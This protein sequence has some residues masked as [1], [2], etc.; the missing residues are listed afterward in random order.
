MRRMR[1]RRCCRVHG[2]GSS[3]LERNTFQESAEGGALQVGHGRWGTR[4]WGS[5]REVFESSAEAYPEQ[6]IFEL[7]RNRPRRPGRR[8][9][10]TGRFNLKLFRVHWLWQAS[11][12]GQWALFVSN[13]T[14]GA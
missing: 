13:D 4:G 11:A 6:C 8:H 7:A 2:R 3:N 14:R 9:R 10:G 12:W 1:R 5:G